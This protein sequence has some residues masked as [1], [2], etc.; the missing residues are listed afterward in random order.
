MKRRN[1]HHITILLVLII[2]ACNKS[3]EVISS[4]VPTN[5]E[6]VFVEY[7]IKK[8]HHY[9]NGNAAQLMGN[10]LDFEVI[11]DSSAIYATQSKENSGDINK[12]YGFS[13]C[14]TLHHENS[15]RVG[16]LWNHDALELYAYCYTN[17]ERNSEF[18][19]IAPLKQKIKLSIEATATDYVFTY[20]EAEAKIARHCSDR[21]IQGYQLFP[22]FGGDETA[23]HNIRILIR[24]L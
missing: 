1:N 24:Q 16:W 18:L 2:A 8:G 19:G 12:L 15:A 13:D 5:E 7:I 17:G 9:S 22:Y 3:A 21:E 4:P 11:F 10:K 23:P 6:D 20:G 14:N